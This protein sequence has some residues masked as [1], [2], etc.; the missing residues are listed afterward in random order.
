MCIAIPILLTNFAQTHRHTHTDTHTHGH[1]HAHSISEF[2]FLIVFYA[3]I[4]KYKQY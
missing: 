2:V 1:A 3:A 4:L